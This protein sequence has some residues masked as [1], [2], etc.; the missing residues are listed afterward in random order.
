MQFAAHSMLH[1]LDEFCVLSLIY[2]RFLCVSLQR[3]EGRGDGRGDGRSDGRGD[4][5]ADGRGDARIQAGECTQ[6]VGIRL[7]SCISVPEFSSCP[8]IFTPVSL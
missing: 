6:P 7:S 2:L 4:G 8:V 1:V 3:T 5:R